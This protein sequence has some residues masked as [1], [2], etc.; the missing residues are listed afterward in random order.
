MS[1]HDY[2]PLPSDPDIIRWRKTGQWCRNTMVRQ[3]LLKR[4]SP[5]GIWEISEEGKRLFRR[6]R[7]KSAPYQGVKVPLLAESPIASANTF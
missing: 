6:A 2:Q 4:D 3:G 7:C 5:R 1:D